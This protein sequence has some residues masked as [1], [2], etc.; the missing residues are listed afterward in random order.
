MAR[1]PESWARTR[2]ER[3]LNFSW[4]R[5]LLYHWL[6]LWPVV[7]NLIGFWWWGVA[8]A[9]PTH[10]YHQVCLCMCVCVCRS[11]RSI[12]LVPELWFLPS[13][14]NPCAGDGSPA[15]VSACACFDFV[16]QSRRCFAGFFHP[17]SSSFSFSLLAS[18]SAAIS[19]QGELSRR[20]SEF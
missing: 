4:V 19:V 11:L 5:G 10:T 18:F 6:W 15:R 9:T 8:T 1:E 12:T 13:R 3:S 2:D 14:N 20:V 7:V 16:M 17:V